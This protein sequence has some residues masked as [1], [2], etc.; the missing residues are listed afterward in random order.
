MKRRKALLLAAAASLALTAGL[1]GCDK[2]G[3]WGNPG[4]AAS[5]AESGTK[6]SLNSSLP[7]VHSFT[8]GTIG[9]GSYT[10]SLLASADVT[11]I[12][13]WQTTCPPCIK[14]MPDLALL[15]GNLPD[16]VQLLTWCLD[17]SY[18]NAKAKQILS[19]AGFGGETIISWSGDLDKLLEKIMY[20]PT[21]V[22]LDSEGNMVCEEIIGSGDVIT[23]YTEHINAALRAM[24]KDEIRLGQT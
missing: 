9:G 2:Y 5:G 10:E 12:N 16:N 6:I 18:N 19:E 17:G 24:G 8:A 11:V 14:E 3:G 20:T 15:E 23:K 1:C 22:F 21:T 7:D 4:T 13:I